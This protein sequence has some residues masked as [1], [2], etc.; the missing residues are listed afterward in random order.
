MRATVRRRR[1]RHQV[2]VRR[3]SY[4]ISRAYSIAVRRERMD[5][6]VVIKNRPSQNLT[7]Y[8]APTADYARRQAQLG[9]GYD[10]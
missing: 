1:D 3:N 9:L 10:F 7:D 4:H 5:G 8:R 2:R 6:D